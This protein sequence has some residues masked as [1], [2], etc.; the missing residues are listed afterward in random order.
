MVLDSTAGKKAREGGV[1]EGRGNR[2]GRRRRG[3]PFFRKV[4][5][6]QYRRAFCCLCQPTVSNQSGAGCCVSGRSPLRT[7]HRGMQREWPR[8]VVTEGR[9]AHGGIGLLGPRKREGEPGRRPGDSSSSSRS[10][11]E[12]TIG[13]RGRQEQTTRTMTRTRT[14]NSSCSGWGGRSPYGGNVHSSEAHP[15]EVVCGRVWLL[16]LSPGRRKCC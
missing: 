5:A 7:R 3:M 8:G 16:R 1:G 4:S 13:R 12:V 6:A 10:K 14:R 11:T 9:L 2:R 15:C